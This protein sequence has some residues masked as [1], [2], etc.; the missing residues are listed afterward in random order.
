MIGQRSSSSSSIPGSPRLTVASAG[1]TSSAAAA[2]GRSIG[3]QQSIR[4]AEQ[5]VATWQKDADITHCPHCFC[6]FGWSTRRHHCRLC[7]K[8]MCDKLTCS[9]MVALP[10]VG[11]IR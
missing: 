5:Q 9:E 6:A 10:P 11:R 4:Q 8:I 2:S 7:G 1:S 3:R